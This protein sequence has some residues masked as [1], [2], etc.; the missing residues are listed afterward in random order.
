M[1]KPSQIPGPGDVA[2]AAA[3]TDALQAM[4]H[5]FAALQGDLANADA[6]AGLLGMAQQIDALIS[7]SERMA[8]ALRRNEQRFELALQAANDGL[9]DYDLRQGTMFYSPRWKSMLGLAED[10]IGNSLQEWMDLIHPEDVPEGMSAFRRYVSGDA[11]EFEAV[12]RVR[13]HQG[14]Y[15]WMRT[16][17]QALRDGDGRAVRVVGT[18]S[19]ITA[20][21]VAESAL[22]QAKEEAE[23]AN[24]A[25]SRFL[26][27]VSHEIRTPMNGVLGMLTLAL[28][29]ELTADQRDY[30][31]LA[32][33]SAGHLLVIL[34]DIL[35]LSKVEAGRMD[36]NAESLDPRLLLDGL[37]R[38]HA[39]AC[40]GKALALRLEI[41]GTIPALIEADPQRLRQVLSNLLGNAI[42]FTPHGEV[43][44]GCRMEQGRLRFSVR[45]TGIGIAP[46]QQ[47]GIFEAFVQADGSFSR[48]YGGTG[49]GLA[50]S[51]H[52]VAMMGGELALRSVPWEGSEFYFSL[53]T[54]G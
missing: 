38:T 39:A 48:L 10:G 26:A 31:G 42:K 43:V 32:R 23:A 2:A 54:S 6:A 17:G 41:E 49:L 7:E 27:N 37:L 22:I 11:H 24:R 1:V 33:E 8:E 15:L 19:D 50:I 3:G 5:A 40:A 53:G 12:F 47:A 51:R 14:H 45:D 4:R 18:Q 52:L 28:A 44:L 20:Q 13:H 34:N 16:R 46:E 9:W 29:T 25:K 21:K 35:D 36:I 30:L